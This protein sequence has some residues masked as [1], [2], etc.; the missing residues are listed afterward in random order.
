MADIKPALTPEQWG[1][2]NGFTGPRSAMEGPDAWIEGDD[3]WFAPS[4]AEWIPESRH[5]VAA[6]ALHGQP[7]GFDFVDV[8]RLREIAEQIDK[9]EL[10]EAW[11][12]RLRD[13]ADR[14]VALLP[15]REE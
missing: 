15:P 8:L 5:A 3:L 2:G 14:I 11:S 4:D 9:K 12:D 1:P 13:V 7:F 10:P 6:L